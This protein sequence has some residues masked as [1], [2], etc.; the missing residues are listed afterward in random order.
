MH[1]RGR[2][3]DRRLERAVRGQ[4]GDRGDPRHRDEPARVA[5]LARWPRRPPGFPIAKIAARLAVG[6]A[7]EE[8]DNDITRR[9]AGVASS[10]RSTTSSSSGRAS[11]SRSSPAP[12]PTLST[13]MKSVGEAMAIGR[14][15]QQAFA[16]GDALARA[17]QAAARSTRSTTTTLLALLERP[18]ADRYDVAA[19]GCSAAARRSRTSTRARRSTRGSCASCRRWRSTPRRRSPASARSSRSTPAP[20]SSR[21][22]TPYYYSGWERARPPTRS[23]AATAPS[24]VILGA[25][26]NRIGQGI[27]FDY[28]CVHA[29]MTVRESRPRR[30]DDQLQPRDGLDRLRHLRPPV[31]RAADARGRA[32]RRRGRAARGRDRPVR[33]PD[34]AEARRRPRARRAC[35]CSARASTR[36][37][38]PRTAAASARCSTALGYEAPPYATARIRRGGAR[39]RAE[40]VGF[41]LLVRPSYVLGG[42]A[43]EIVYSRRRPARLPAR[44]GDRAGDG[45]RDLPRPLPGE[46]DRGRRRRAVRRR[47]RLDRRDHAARRGGRHPLRRQRLRAAAALAR[48]TRCSSR[49]ART[50]AASRSASASSA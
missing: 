8:I 50:R 22:R 11:P 31:L 40:T 33:R 25:G 44:S 16:Q 23:S 38:S 37:T 13:H 47:G 43:M 21:P 20:P 14:T 9:H 10:R 34:A 48:R 18:A 46:R 3:R 27:E 45:P 19:R 26:P 24:V 2:R 49:S 5:L 6:Y 39:A 42:R 32:R 4:P 35:R 28:C 12:T 41:P 7:L 29:A 30:G 17:R 15:F 36:S 1:P